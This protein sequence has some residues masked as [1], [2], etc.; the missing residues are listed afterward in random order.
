MTGTNSLR[1]L[2]FKVLERDNAGTAA[3]TR[4]KKLVPHPPRRTTPVGQACPAGWDAETTVLIEWF[5]GTEPPT[6]PF[7]LQ[8]AV[9]I[10]RADRYW[11]YLK[12]DIA[13]GPNRARGRTG[14]LHDD[15]KRLHQLFGAG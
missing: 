2:A 4:A 15:L 5:L 12:G 13:A 8:Q 7:E 9:F 6:Q 10:A 14:A 11:E 3:G 1:A